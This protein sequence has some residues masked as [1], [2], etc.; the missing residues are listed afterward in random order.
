[1]LRML[2]LILM[3]PIMASVAPDTTDTY[4]VATDG[5]E[6]NDGSPEKPWPS[7][8]YAL[9]QVGGGHTIVVRPGT[10]AGRIVIE[11]QYAGTEQRPTVIRSEV[12]WKAVIIGSTQHGIWTDPGTEWVA[13]DGFEVLGARFDGVNLC[14]DHNTVR[15]CWVHNNTEMGIACFHRTGCTI[16][17]NLVEFNGS[18]IWFH[19]G[20]YAN[21]DQLTLRGNIVRHNSGWGLHLYPDIR[22][23]VLANN[24]IF[25]H[26]HGWGVILSCPEGGGKNRVVNNTVAG[27]NGALQVVRGDGE[28]VVNNILV[29]PFEALRFDEA[30]RNVRADYNLCSPPSARQ[31]PH[32]VA[33][34]P[35]FVEPTRGVYWLQADSPAIGQGTAE[36]APPTDFW[37]RPLPQDK[38]PDLGAFVFVPSLATPE[39]RAGWYYGWPYQF[40]PNQEMG[41]P[42]LWALPEGTD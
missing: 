30:T 24:L 37:G 8:Q 42:D 15:N 19:H 16:E 41:L 22:N 3:C 25:D 5:Q 26:P 10:Y 40:Y 35:G 12:K 29:D 21:G 36:Y 18:H 7:I 23:S 27:C 20:I 9:S 34:S 31:G 13:I 17:N 32:G 6:G 11:K 1:M 14:G 33:G 28:V 2:E 39:A 4:Y 38:P